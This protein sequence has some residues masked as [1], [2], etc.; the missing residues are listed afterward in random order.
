MV[1]ALL[2]LLQGR[3]DCSADNSICIHPGERAE[4]RG[5]SPRLRV[6]GIEH[7]LVLDFDVAPLKGRVVE[8]AR[9][10]MLPAGE[11]KLKTMGVSTVAAPWKEKEC[12]FNGPWPGGGDFHSVAF[13]RGGSIWTVRDARAE[14]DGWL[15][16]EIPPP[17]VHAMVERASHGIAVSDEKGQTMHNNDVFAREQSGKTPYLVVK[18]K[19]GKAP[20][21][22]AK[23]HKPEPEPGVVAREFAAS[24]AR[25]CR[26]RC[27]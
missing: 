6:K 13:S 5:G 24:A 3:L 25:A 26:S 14:K 27:A 23:L 19:P 16:L 9:L 18:S 10:W 21:S 2:L 4:N 7:I 11:H 12:T 1:L 22:G 20:P 17:I 8:E 15:S